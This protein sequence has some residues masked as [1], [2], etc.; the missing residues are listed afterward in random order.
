MSKDD[1]IVSIDDTV[2]IDTSWFGDMGNITVAS[3]SY[4]SG[5]VLTSNGTTSSPNWSTSISNNLKGGQ[6]ELEG[7]GA[8]IVINGK[9]LSMVME[10][11]ESRL[12]ILTPDPEKLEHFEAL[13]KAY[14]HYKAL[15][16]LCQLPKEDKDD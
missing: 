2:T 4:P 10:K 3:T 6:L 16:A 13:K 11:I 14:D 12:A 7:E 8:D 5:S 15:E 1:N 9:S